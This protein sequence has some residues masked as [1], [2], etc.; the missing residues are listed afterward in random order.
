MRC[1]E[2]REI[3]RRQRGSASSKPRG[4]GPT[5]EWTKGKRTRSRSCRDYFG[6]SAARTASQQCWT[7]L[8]G[9][10]QEAR[11]AGQ[12]LL[13]VG[14]L[15]PVRKTAVFYVVHMSIYF[16]SSV[17]SPSASTASFKKGKHSS[18]VAPSAFFGVIAITLYCDPI[19]V[20]SMRRLA[21]LSI[22]F[23]RS[24]EAERSRPARRGWRPR[25]VRKVDW[26]RGPWE[27]AGLA[28][29]KGRA[30]AGRRGEAASAS[31]KT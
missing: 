4:S 2:K 11:R 30:G 10:A 9:D 3:R 16:F 28:D 6:H 26:G 19:P 1:S 31:L 18:S 21:A 29:V 24:G 27:M 25:E 20:L 12:G 23:L 5:C 8:L 17:P 15:V 7:P 22:S 14:Y 13:T